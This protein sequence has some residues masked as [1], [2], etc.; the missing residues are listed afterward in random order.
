MFQILQRLLI[1]L[2]R[3]DGN[4]L[5][6]MCYAKAL[7]QKNDWYSKGVAFTEIGQYKKAI[8]CFNNALVVDEKHKELWKNKGIAFY[9][10]GQYAEAIACYDKGLAID[11][12]DIS[13]LNSKAYNFFLLGQYEEAISCYDMAL[14]I[15]AKNKWTWSDK[16]IVMLSQNKNNL[17]KVKSVFD[18]ALKIDK[19][20]Y[21][22]LLGYYLIAF[23]EQRIEATHHYL[24][25]SEKKCTAFK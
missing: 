15:D 18:E 2:F 24:K 20:L 3:A 11:A 7:R 12:N 13:C 23:A 9:H 4:I 25:K 19:N 10:L 16:G 6:L 8:A 21:F 14:V 1:T 5:M 22:G 17:E